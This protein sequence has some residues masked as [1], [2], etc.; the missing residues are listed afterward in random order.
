[1]N[2]NLLLESTNE[3]VVLDF[4]K[5]T[6]NG[7]KYEGN[8][9]LAGGAV[10]DSVMG[11]KPKDLDFVVNGDLNSG[12]NFSVWLANIIGNYKEGSNPVVYPRFGTSKL[13]LNG[14]KFNL[15]NI[16]LEF[17]APRTEKYST[18][19]RKPDVGNGTL[20]D[21]VFRRD[22][23][24]NSLLQNV[25]TGEILDL[26]GHGISDIKNG[27][28]RTTSEPDIIFADDPLRL[29][30]V[31]RFSSKYGFKIEPDVLGGIKKNAHLID[32][33][34]KERI[35][36]EL[37]KIIMSDRPSEGIQ[38]LKDTG[39]LSHIMPEFNNAIG[40]TQNAHHK[41]D[42]F[43]HTM[44]VLSKTPPQLKT[45]LM[46]L[47][48]DIGKTL[49]RSVSPDGSVHFY[50]HEK[51]GQDIARDI[52]TRLK[53]PNDLINA[54]ISGIG[55]HMSLKQGGDDAVGVSDKTLRKFAANVGDNLNDI[56]DLIHA[57]NISHADESAMP[58]QIELIRGR[59]NK[60][61]NDLDN[62]KPKL[63]INGN[64]LIK[65]GL[66]PSPLFRDILNA[67]EDAWFENPNISRDEAMKIVNAMKGNNDVNEVKSLINRIK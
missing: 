7:T 57:D 60:L 36:D 48:H 40:M 13:S 24:I 23:S 16:E 4:L 18:G 12:I 58:N 35:S 51:V 67:V 27:V 52:M 20:K 62:H 49:T 44:D 65:I 32:S 28:I 37:S 11:K 41:H 38:M 45:R 47:F 33:I 56:L 8:V 39:L 63:P 19:S 34:S 31:V 54:V 42:V 9:F 5:N 6:I 25:S 61:N 17:V 55:N 21:D 64:D 14:N 30:R 29:L 1:M 22:L 43:G 50:G 46:A 15:P 59:L 10:R 26:T 53:Y 3:D 2:K 66:K